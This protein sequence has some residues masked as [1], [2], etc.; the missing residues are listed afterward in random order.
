MWADILLAGLCTIIGFPVFMALAMTYVPSSHGGVVLGI[1]VTNDFLAWVN[2]LDTYGHLYP[3]SGQ[4]TR[5]AIDA[6]FSRRM[7]T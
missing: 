2:A 1:L 7:S 3:D 5:A 4:T 6:A